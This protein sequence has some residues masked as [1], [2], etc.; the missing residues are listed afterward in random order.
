MRPVQ[1]TSFQI[2]IARYENEGYAAGILKNSAF[3]LPL[4]DMK[5]RDTLQASLKT[6]LSNSPCKI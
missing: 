1:K 4:Q 2:A 5:M 3:K 6:Q